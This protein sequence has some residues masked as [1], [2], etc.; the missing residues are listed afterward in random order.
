VRT[1]L[2]PKLHTSCSIRSSSVATTRRWS[3]GE[4]E[5]RS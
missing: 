3:I 4:R 1:Q 2:P 5:A